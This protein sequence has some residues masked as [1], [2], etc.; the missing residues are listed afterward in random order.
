MIKN[1]FKNYIS[2]GFHSM[3][4]LYDYRMVYNAYAARHWYEKGIPVM[5]SRNHHDG[6]P[7]FGGEYFIVVAE[8]ESGQV[9]NHYP[10]EYWVIFDIPEGDTPPEWD[11]HDSSLALRRMMIDLIP[12]DRGLNQDDVKK[13]LT[14]PSLEERVAPRRGTLY[15]EILDNNN[16]RL[17]F[18]FWN[19]E[20]NVGILP[21]DEYEWTFFVTFEEFSDS[22]LTG[23]DHI[24]VVWL[25]DETDYNE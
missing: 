24:R 25:K 14:L 18:G 10:I 11:G 17:W 12:Y 15:F 13:L 23:A 7:C 2:D 1:M 19:D 16:D 8:L 4:E 21:R 20:G 9:S 6:E 22:I 3:Q 5:K